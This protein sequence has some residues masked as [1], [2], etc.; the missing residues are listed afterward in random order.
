MFL[1]ST[2]ISCTSRHSI[3]FSLSSSISIDSSIRHHFILFQIRVYILAKINLYKFSFCSYT[4]LVSE[5]NHV[6]YSYYYTLWILISNISTQGRG[7]YEGS[8]DMIILLLGATHKYCHPL[9]NTKD[10]T[11]ELW[12]YHISIRSKISWKVLCPSEEISDIK[13]RKIGKHHLFW[14]ILLKTNLLR[15]VTCTI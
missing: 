3:I 12:Y 13:V 2:S 4:I 11:D 6:L 7:Y 14:S 8:L 9:T 1:I 15:Y 10:F 5:C